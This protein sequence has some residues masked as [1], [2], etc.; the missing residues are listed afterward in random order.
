MRPLPCVLLRRPDR[1]WRVYWT[2]AVEKVEDEEF[3][4]EVSPQASQAKASCLRVSRESILAPRNRSLWPCS[5]WKLKDWLM[6]AV[7]WKYVEGENSVFYVLHVSW[8]VLIHDIKSWIT[9]L[10]QSFKL[11]AYILKFLSEI[12]GFVFVLFFQFDLNL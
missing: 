11:F 1:E 10:N 8:D 7:W 2:S 12:F 5:T 6:C 9:W 3:D 4:D